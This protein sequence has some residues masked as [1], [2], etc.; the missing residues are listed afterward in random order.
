MLVEKLLILG[1]FDSEDSGCILQ[2]FGINVFDG[3][4]FFGDNF[5]VLIFAL[6]LVDGGIGVVATAEKK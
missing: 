1:L 6:N 2:F 5:P 3:F 4:D